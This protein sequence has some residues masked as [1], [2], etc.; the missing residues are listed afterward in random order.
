MRRCPETQSPSRRDMAC[1][2]PETEQGEAH[3]PDHK[4]EKA[5]RR[6]SNGASTVGDSGGLAKAPVL[7]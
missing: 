4:E 6:Q 3:Q 2:Y 1:L 5:F 7:G